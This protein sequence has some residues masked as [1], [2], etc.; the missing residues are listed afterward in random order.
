MEIVN[1]LCPSSKKMVHIALCM[2]VGW[3]VYLDS[4]FPTA[5]ERIIKIARSRDSLDFNLV[6]SLY[7]R[8]LLSADQGGGNVKIITD[9]VA[10]GGGG[11]MLTFIK[12]SVVIM[13]HSLIYSLV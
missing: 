9:F 11:V 7:L 12:I 6:S 10:A 2:S 5:C 8:S 3:S 4:R 1:S 13:A